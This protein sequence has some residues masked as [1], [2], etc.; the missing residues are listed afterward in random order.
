MKLKAPEEFR[1]GPLPKADQKD[2]EI[3][4]LPLIESLQHLWREFFQKPTF[5]RHEE[6]SECYIARVS[7]IKIEL[8]FIIYF[9]D[10]C[11]PEHLERL[12]SSLPNT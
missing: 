2:S 1:S 3:K 8:P 5:R 10:V 9:R 6:N 11:F 7:V 12:F 4:Q